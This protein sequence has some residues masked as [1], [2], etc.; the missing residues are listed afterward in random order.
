MSLQPEQSIAS[1]D[2]IS[3][4]DASE[5]WK[6][7]VNEYSRETGKALLDHP[8]AFE[9][10]QQSSSEKVI[11]LLKQFVA[12]RENGGKILQVVK[13]IVSFILNFIDAGAEGASVRVPC[14]SNS[15]TE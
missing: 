5:R 3:V 10:L 14:H 13:P 9:I 8:F 2:G 15:G 12:F 4:D 7:A 6:Q 1:S 11:A